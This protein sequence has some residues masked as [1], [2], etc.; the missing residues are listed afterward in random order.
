[1]L[2]ESFYIRELRDH[3]LP[4]VYRSWLRTF[5]RSE[6]RGPVHDLDY[7]ATYRPTVE[8]LLKRSHTL[9]MSDALDTT[10][11][12][13]I[14]Y[15]VYEPVPEV[16][17]RRRTIRTL[18]TPVV[19]WLYVKGDHD[20]NFRKHGV[21]TALLDT[22]LEGKSGCFYTFRTSHARRFSRRYVLTYSPEYARR[23]RPCEVQDIFKAE[24]TSK[25]T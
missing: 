4:F 13:I 12:Q 7:Y 23:L 19:H 10:G 21:G 5:K 9:V 24:Q 6:D 14:G 11:R 22:A 18:G 25:E 15:I 8:R 3:D 20:C 17:T 2:P 1:M 16:F